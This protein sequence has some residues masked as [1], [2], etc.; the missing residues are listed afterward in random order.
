VS[1]VAAAGARQRFSLSVS[2][3]VI[4]RDAEQKLLLLRRAH[5]GWHDGSFSLPAG[6][7]DGAQPL[8]ASAAR[9]LREETGLQASADDLRL[10]HLLHC[11]AGDAG[12]EWLGAFFSA[13]SWTG[14]PALMEPEKH[15]HLDWHALQ[16]LPANTIAYVRQGIELGLRG[17]RFS[18]YGEFGCPPSARS[19]RAA[20]ATTQPTSPSHRIVEG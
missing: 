19:G 13:E 5:T 20:N 18:T 17:I 12:T 10:V 2:V 6:G 4:V 1:D 15:D 16:A 3:F 9:E 14:T 11:A 7:H 8:A